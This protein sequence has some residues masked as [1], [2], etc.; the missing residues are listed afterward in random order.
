MPAF[1]MTIQVKP[2]CAESA[3][4]QLAEIQRLARADK[5]NQAFFWLRHTTDPAQFTLFEEWD[6]QA[7]LDAH[8]AHI[9]PAWDRFEP[10]LAD[11]P[12]SEPVIPVSS[13]RNVQ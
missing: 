5:G 7:N 6:T 11:N 4:G 2:D 9:T 10:L 12:V 1:L 8:L 3:V 13:M